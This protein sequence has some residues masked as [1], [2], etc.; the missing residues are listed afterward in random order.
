MTA[1]R[2]LAADVAAGRYEDAVDT[3]LALA[4]RDGFPARRAEA[5]KRGKL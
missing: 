2:R 4:D 5:R 1:T 3:A